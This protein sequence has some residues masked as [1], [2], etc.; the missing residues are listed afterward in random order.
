M[1]FGPVP[2]AQAEGALLA[3][4]QQIGRRRLPKGHVLSAADLTDASASGLAEL[5]VAQLEPGDVAEDDAATQLA[6]ALAG[7]GLAAL[8]PVHGRVNLAATAA[9][10]FTAPPG[11]VAA[12]NAVDEAL[13]LA[14]LPSG[15]RV[16]AG[17]IVATIKTINYAV[18][19]GALTTAI[20]AARPLMVAAFRPLSITLIATTLPGT[21]A[22]A[23]AKLERVTAARI[24]A[25]GSRMEMLPPCPHETA[26]LAARLAGCSTDLLLVAGASATVDRGDVIPQAIVAA[27]GTVE[28]LGMP[29]DPGN[30]LVL[31]TLAGRPV[32]GLPGCAK[33]P[34]RNGFDLVL[35]RLAAGLAVTAD[36]IA[37]MGDGGLLPEAERPE[38]RA[39]ASAPR[40]VGAVLLAAGRSSRFGAGHKLLAPWRGKPLVAHAVDAIA[41][42]GLPPPIVVLGHD[43]AAVRAALAG[44]DVQFVAAPDWADGMG[45]SLAAGIAA[46]PADWDA[47]LICLGDMPAVEPALIA[48][49]A[50]APGEL[51]VPLWDGR[52]GHPV[53]WPRAAFARLLALTGD[54]GGKAAMGDFTVTEI[55]APS[56]ACLVDIDTPTALA[57]LAAGE[58]G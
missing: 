49:L 20:A 10:L 4:G 25:L 5:V 46:V 58:A 44:Y 42:A 7:A 41:A 21:N 53:R 12:V 50:A 33:S 39:V 23:L 30:L 14:A 24:K 31:G 16:A 56:A 17:A 48:A 55:A 22:K 37:A 11:M 2:L 36:T 40:R 57:K 19:G 51:V 15:T 35:E 38:P 18:T 1:K 26:A 32:I 3:H 54:T 13:T 45:H 28:R 8:A 34:K 52:R 27:G 43:E 6:A 29:V 9:G 47:A